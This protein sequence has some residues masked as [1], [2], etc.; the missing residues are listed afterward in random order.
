LHSCGATPREF[1]DCVTVKRITQREVEECIQEERGSSKVWERGFGGITIDKLEKERL[2]TTTGGAET[3][4]QGPAC[5]ESDRSWSGGDK[6]EERSRRK[7]RESVMRSGGV[8]CF[9]PTE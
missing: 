8:C 7:S 4:G 6:V 5:S 2:A 9:E 3:A 1:S